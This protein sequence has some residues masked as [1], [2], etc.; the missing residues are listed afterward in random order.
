[1][2]RMLILHATWRQHDARPNPPQ[3]ARQANRMFRSDLKMRVAAEVQEFNRCAQYPRGFLR[4]G[5]ALIGCSVRA[6]FAARANHQMHFPAQ[7]RLR[8]NHAAAS[9]LDVIGMGAKRQQRGGF[10]WG[11]RSRLHRIV[12]WLHVEQR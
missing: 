4:L 9:E 12:Q 8:R 10:S 7:T 6:G 3:H 1:M 2:I 11:I 5:L